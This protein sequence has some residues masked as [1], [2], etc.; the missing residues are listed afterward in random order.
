MLI[1][2]KSKK[3]ITTLKAQLSSDFEMKDLGAAKKILGI[4]ITRDRKFGLLFLCQHNYT[5]KVLYRFNMPHA[6]KVTTP[7]A[8]HFKLL[9]TQYPVTDE[10]IEYM[11]RD[12]Y[13]SVVIS[14]LMY[15]MVSSC[16]DLSYAMS[17]V[18]RYMTNPDKEY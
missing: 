17:L 6:K 12:P 3:E 1:V 4:E 8:P 16:P 10:D 7:I 2:A 9:S 11:S 15:V 14:S 18:S 5:N 13:S